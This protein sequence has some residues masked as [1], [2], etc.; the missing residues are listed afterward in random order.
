MSAAILLL[1]LAVQAQQPPAVSTTTAA[2]KPP[3]LRRLAMEEIPRFNDSFPGEHARQGLLRAAKR[4]MAYLAKLPPKTFKLADRDYAPA[5]LEDTLKEFTALWEQ[6]LPPD[7]F[8]RQVAARFE[9]FQSI[10]LDGQGRVVFSSYYQPV[11]EASLKRTERFK[12]PIY[13]RPADMV[14]VPLAE[15]GGK[16]G[17]ATLI[18]RVGKDRRVVPYFGRDEID[19]HKAL[20]GKG[21]ELAWLADRFD[22][23]DLHIQGS[24]ILKLP[25]GKEVLAGYA[26][27]NAR[28]YNSVGLSLVKAGVF[29]REEITHDKLRQYFRSHPEAAAW[30]LAQNP[31]YTFFKL[32]PLPKDGEP[33]GT[34]EASLT[35]ARSIAIDPEAVPLGALA[36]FSTTSPQA[37]DQGRLLG[38]FPN[39]RFAVCMDT[40]GAIKGPGRVDIY[41]GHG[42]MAATTARNQWADGKLFILVK[43]VPPRER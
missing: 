2:P 15:F 17:E 24:G 25:S 12:H 39:S 9:T 43:K 3:A 29:T 42:P 36:Y 26:A 21:M 14:E 30:A 16:H 23:L 4:A 34:M 27:T 8:D 19:F 7:E 40:G 38:S 41:A 28:T 22:I 13:R 1:A 33:M 5:I 37:D 18:G 10:G 32:S 35:P 11:L 6:G 31:R 20:A